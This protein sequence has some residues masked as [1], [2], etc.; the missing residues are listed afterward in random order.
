MQKGG[1]PGH[2]QSDA[3]TWLRKGCSM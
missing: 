1:I 3:L 2:S